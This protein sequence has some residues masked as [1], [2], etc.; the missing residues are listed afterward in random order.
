M[1][2]K[3]LA[4][5]PVVEGVVV[6]LSECKSLQ[7]A[8]SIIEEY[9]MAQ[10]PVVLAATQLNL[11]HDPLIALSS[12]LI[13]ENAG[14]VSH[15]AQRAREL[16]RGAVGGIDIRGLRSGT[17]VRLDPAARLVRKIDLR[18]Q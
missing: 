6:N 11:S 15:G 1:R 12:G 7:H 16:G 17:A 5:G 13:I 18:M 8:I 14:L 10:V 2:G 4:S 9:L 3:F